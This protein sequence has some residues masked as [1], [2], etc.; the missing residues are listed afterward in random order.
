[1]DPQLQAEGCLEVRFLPHTH[2]LCG[3]R[4][5]AHALL[6]PSSVQGSLF[7]LGAHQNRN[8]DV[9]TVRHWHTAV[10]TTTIPRL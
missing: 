9:H 2:T 3:T 5:A 7:F 4:S 1:M 8:A 10:T 6:V